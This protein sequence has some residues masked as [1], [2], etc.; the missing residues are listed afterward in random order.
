MLNLTQHDATPEQLA[1]GVVEPSGPTKAAIR[2]LLTFP[3]VDSDSLDGIPTAADIESA[4]EVLAIRAEEEGATKVMIGG[5]PYLMAPLQRAL[6]SAGIIPY[7]AFSVRESIEESQPDGS[8][9]KTTT[10]RHLGFIRAVE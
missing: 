10:F 7:Y 8:V 9:R 1:A 2:E 5:A 4:A 6:L 3:A